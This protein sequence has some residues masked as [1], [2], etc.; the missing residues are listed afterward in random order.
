[1]IV[2]CSCRLARKFEPSRVEG[3]KRRVLSYQLERE[4]Q[5]NKR[6][7]AIVRSQSSRR[8]YGGG[9]EL[10]H[11]N[12][13]AGSKHSLSSPGQSQPVGGGRS[14]SRSFSHHIIQSEIPDMGGALWKRE[15]MHIQITPWDQER[16]DENT[17]K[18]DCD[19]KVHSQYKTKSLQED[20]LSELSRQNYNNQTRKVAGEK[21]RSSRS[22][23]RNEIEVAMYLPQRL[24]VDAQ[25]SGSTGS[26]GRQ[27]R[28][29][30]FFKKQRRR[31]AQT[32]L[33]HW[34][35]NF[36]VLLSVYLYSYVFVSVMFACIGTSECFYALCVNVFTYPFMQLSLHAEF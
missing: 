26:N 24:C 9:D 35:D 28:T 14:V 21:Q 12:D 19:E 31:K 15:D 20:D 27:R 13:V 18:W 17:I 23:E 22:L 25:L 11:F 33:N 10:Q 34:R 7:D 8:V 3:A 5:R 4:G 1:V 2:L 36:F 6:R 32:P 16:R 30:D 29:E